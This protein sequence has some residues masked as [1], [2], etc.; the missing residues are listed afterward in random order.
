MIDPPFFYKW[1]KPAIF[2]LMVNDCILNTILMLLF[3]V[4][5]K[6]NIQESET[7]SSIEWNQFADDNN[8]QHRLSKYSLSFN[9]F[10]KQNRSIIDIITLHTNLFGAAIVTNQLFLA[11]L[12]SGFW[13]EPIQFYIFLFRG[14]ECCANVLVLYLSFGENRKSYSKYCRACHRATKRCCVYATKRKV[15]R[16]LFNQLSPINSIAGKPSPSDGPSSPVTI[17]LDQGDEFVVLEEELRYNPG[18]YQ[19]PERASETVVKA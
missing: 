18:T 11:S 3:V 6:H 12:I 13:F 19:P 1:A 15:K 5:L 9:Q 16:N 7:N 2:I 10:S 4:R 8:G 14:I 17:D